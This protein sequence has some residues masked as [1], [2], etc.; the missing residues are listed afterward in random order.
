MIPSNDLH[1]SNRQEVLQ[2][3]SM[4]RTQALVQSEALEHAC[5]YAR[6]KT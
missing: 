4:Q 5:S 1:L 6:R 2:T 3:A